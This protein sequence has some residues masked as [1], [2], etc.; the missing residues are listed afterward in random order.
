MATTLGIRL[1]LCAMAALLL[2]ACASTTP[3][4][5]QRFGDSVRATLTSQVANPAAGANRNPVA[6]IDGRAASA[7]QERYEHSFA[8]PTPPPPVLINVR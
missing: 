4:F 1:V 8:Q 5:D 7:A 6:G 2:S 3:I